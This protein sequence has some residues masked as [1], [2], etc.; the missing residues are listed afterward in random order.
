MISVIVECKHQNL[1][2]E[3]D[4]KIDM[5]DK[6]IEPILLYEGWGFH[7]SYLYQK[8]HLKFYNIYLTLEGG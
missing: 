8:L 6:V 7:N 4:C 1:A 3:V 2:I 5:F